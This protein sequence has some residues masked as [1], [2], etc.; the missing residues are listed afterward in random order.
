MRNRVRFIVLIVVCLFLL[1][2]VSCQP[3]PEPIKHSF[4]ELY[5][6]W[7]QDGYQDTMGFDSE[8]YVSVSS[9]NIR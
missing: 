6:T 1:L 4:E 5:G 3:E 2:C 8:L 9:S 7:T